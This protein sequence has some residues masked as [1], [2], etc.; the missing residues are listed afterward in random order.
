RAA[1]G[2]AGA[3]G[4][5]CRSRHHAAG[6]RRDGRDESGEAR[7]AARRRHSRDRREHVVRTRSRW[8]HDRGIRPVAGAEARHRVECA[9]HREASDRSRDRAALRRRSHRVV[10]VARVGGAHRELPGARPGEAPAGPGRIDAIT[11]AEA[12]RLAIHAQLLD[13]KRRPTAAAIL[14][15]VEHLGYLQLD[16]T[17]VVARNQLLV[18]WSRLGRYKLADFDRVMWEDRALFEYITFIAP[19]SDLPLHAL[20]MQGVR[21][22]DTSYAGRMTS[23]VKRNAALRRHVLGRLRTEGP[24]P[25]GAF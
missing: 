3:A 1:H 17:N 13:R 19:I 24:L 20:R 23:W 12:R 16:P 5:R 4:R 8:L 9:A 7:Q 21:R 14:K 15:T 6:A 22:G 18:L 2:D 25:V 10:R 11:L